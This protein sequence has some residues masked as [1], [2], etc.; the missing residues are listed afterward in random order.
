MINMVHTRWNEVTH[1]LPFCCQ[2]CGTLGCTLGRRADV[3]GSASGIPPATMIRF[4]G[5]VPVSHQS[6]VLLVVSLP[7]L[8]RLWQSRFVFGNNS[9]RTPNSAFSHGW[10]SVSGLLFAA[11]TCF[12]KSQNGKKLTWR[13][14][15]CIP[16]IPIGVVTVISGG[17]PCFPRHHF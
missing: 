8:S 6:R 7:V 10:T 17:I 16:N 15:S 9:P 5:R 1:G 12:I 3:S 4:K 2:S 11:A 13:Y 14:R